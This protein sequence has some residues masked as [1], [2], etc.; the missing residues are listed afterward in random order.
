MPMFPIITER[1]KRQCVSLSIA[2]STLSFAFCFCIVLVWITSSR[3]SDDRVPPKRR[4]HT[5]ILQIFYGRVTISWNSAIAR[6]EQLLR[7]RCFVTRANY[8]SRRANS[9]LR[10]L[11]A[12]PLRLNSLSRHFSL[13]R[14]SHLNQHCHGPGSSR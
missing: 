5:G 3:Q 13:D 11:P 14:T 12:S 8:R 1:K 7:F 2:E 10:Q 9:R 4:T 6:P